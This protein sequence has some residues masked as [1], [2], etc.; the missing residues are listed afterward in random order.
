MVDIDTFDRVPV[1][2]TNDSWNSCDPRPP[3]IEVP[4]PLA[5]LFQ[6]IQSHP[7]L[8]IFRINGSSKRISCLFE[9]LG[10][11]PHNSRD[12]LVMVEDPECTEWDNSY[13]IHDYCGCLKRLLYACYPELLTPRVTRRLT[14]QN[15]SNS[16]QYVIAQ[17]HTPSNVHH[18]QM[19]LYLVFQLHLLVQNSISITK[20]TAHNYAIVFQP[21]FF[22]CETTET[23]TNATRL[24]ESLIVN[25][26][27]VISQYYHY[28]PSLDE[29]EESSC[30]SEDEFY[31]VVQIGSF[32]NNNSMEKLSQTT[33]NN[34]SKLRRKSLIRLFKSSD[35]IDK[36]AYDNLTSIVAS[37]PAT[38]PTPA[39]ISASASY[40]HLSDIQKDA[41]PPLPSLVPPKRRIS[42]FEKSNNKTKHRLSISSPVGVR[43]Q[44]LPSLPLTPTS[45]TSNYKAQPCLETI[46]S[47]NG[48]RRGSS[49]SSTEFHCKSTTTVD[50]TSRRFSFFR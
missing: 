46:P 3:P 45:P 29:I 38:V 15:R 6:H 8:G 35:S 43:V 5:T 40:H 30:S 11:L 42:F 36:P 37:S 50:R 34:Y 28:K 12:L 44:S 33:L 23:M 26:P 47:A 19:F 41:P 21:L 16:F 18:S 14:S 9:L 7:A 25:A 13:T 27:Q 31:D 20:M 10:D 49:T 32:H 22:N 39:S 17:L 1:D 24:L 4:K 2:L 48:S